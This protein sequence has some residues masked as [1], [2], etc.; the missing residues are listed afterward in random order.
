MIQKYSS[1]ADQNATNI[2]KQNIILEKSNGLKFL[3]LLQAYRKLHQKE[4]VKD[5][6]FDFEKK[7][8]EPVVYNID[9]YINTVAAI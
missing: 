4:L 2:S 3:F 9:L 5:T 8:N 1:F 6:V 7:R